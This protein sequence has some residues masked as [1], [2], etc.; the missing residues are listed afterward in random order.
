MAGLDGGCPARVAGRAIGRQGASQVQRPL[1][2]Y[3]PHYA[4]PP[5]IYVPYLIFHVPVTGTWMWFGINSQLSSILAFSTDLKRI[6]TLHSLF[7]VFR[8]DKIFTIHWS[9]GRVQD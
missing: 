3:R 8:T 1:I 9:G 7:R 2:S 5:K 6:Q 4:P